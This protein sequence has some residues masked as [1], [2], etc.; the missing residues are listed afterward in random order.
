M[1]KTYVVSVPE[2]WFQ[3]VRIVAN[4]PS[5]AIDK[6]D[7]GGGEYLDNEL[8]YSHTLEPEAQPWGVEEE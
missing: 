3:K 2:V 4:S 8:S 6:I 5:E 7:N 1:S